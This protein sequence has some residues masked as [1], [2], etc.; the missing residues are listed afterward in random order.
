MRRGRPTGLNSG[1]LIYR[2]TESHVFDADR[3]AIRGRI[4][5]ASHSQMIDWLKEQ[6][7]T[8]KQAEKAHA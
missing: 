3:Q 1:Q 7:K 5:Y 2:M 6:V 4:P 8:R